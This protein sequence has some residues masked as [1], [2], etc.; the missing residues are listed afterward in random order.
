MGAWRLGCCMRELFAIVARKAAT[1]HGCVTTQDLREAGVDKACAWRWLADGRLH[2]MHHGV[3]AVGHPGRTT[4]GDYLA[5]VL[6]CGEGAVLSHAPAAHLLKLLRGAPPPPEVTVPTSAA[7]GVRASSSIA[8]ARCLPAT[9]SSWTASRSRRCRARCSTSR[10][11]CGRS[12]SHARATRRGCTTA[13]AAPRRGLHRAQPGQA[14]RREAAT[15]ARCGRHAQR[16]EA[17]FLRLLRAHG[18]PLPR[19]NIDHA[20]D[21]VDCHWPQHGLTIELLSYRYHASRHA[22]EQDVARRRRSNHIAYTYGDVFE[23]GAATAADVARRLGL[24]RA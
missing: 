17:G 3:Y 12:D 1:Q 20:G 4:L 16:L 14:R 15:S 24:S 6:A 19:T 22:F 5:A 21:K 9:T 10:R 7:A 18:L 2:R 11:R 13:R 8:S 23:R